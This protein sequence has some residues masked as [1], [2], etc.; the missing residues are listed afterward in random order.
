MM[1]KTHIVGGDRLGT[2]KFLKSTGKF[3][4]TDPVQAE[5]YVYTGGE[6]IGSSL[7]GENPV[8]SYSGSVCY[9]D[10]MEVK[11]FQYGKEKGKYHFGICRGHQ[12]LWVLT[13]GKLWQ[14][15]QG[16]GAEPEHHRMILRGK[17]RV[18]TGVTSYHHQAARVYAA[19]EN[20][21]ILGVVKEPQ[22]V[23]VF[24]EGT[25]STVYE[26]VEAFYDPEARTFGVQGHPEF[27]GASGE[28]QKYVV[29]HILETI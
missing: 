18:I 14:H 15:I 1:I 16:H 27:G 12:L 4:L 21:K 26:I 9:R 22:G 10:P 6:D 20:A 2:E 11:A 17:G 7:Y 25:R 28:F 24:A 19:A 13:G 3:E 5:L 8:Y 23:D 29:N